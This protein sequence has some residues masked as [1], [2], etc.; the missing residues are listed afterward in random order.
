MNKWYRSAPAK[1]VLL[2]LQQVFVVLVVV[3][4]IW[5]AAY[6]GLS[7]DIVS[8]KKEDSY[9]D[10]EG[11]GKQSYWYA[12]DL[13]S[14]ISDKDDL[15]TD[16]TLDTNKL[17]DINDLCESG[18][19]SGQNKNGLAYTIQE[20][21][22]W[23]S[24]MEAGTVQASD[25]GTG[26]SSD[27]II[28][29]QKQDGGYDYYYY[30][31]LKK[32]V[33]AGELSFMTD[34]DT[35]MSSE[36]ILGNLQKNTLYQGDGA[37][38]MVDSNNQ[39]VYRTVW[40]YD[41][42]WLEEAYAP[43]GAGSIL[44]IV[45]DNPEWN[46]KLSE[47]FSNIQTAISMIQEK[48]SNYN[49]I[50]DVWEEGNTNLT[51]LY[52]D[53]SAKK[54][55]TNRTEFQDYDQ[56]EENLKKLKEEG[57]YTIVRP[58]LAQ[59][60]SN[61]NGVGADEWRHTVANMGPNSENFV[62]A[63]G[64]DTKY[65]VQDSYYSQNELFEKYA[66][67]IR[68]VILMGI[69][70]VA[71]ILAVIIWMTVTAG[72]SYKDE[73]LHLNGFDKIKTEIA[74]V[75]TVAA[76]YLLIYFG[77]N[78]Y[79]P[80]TGQI[81]QGS[82]DYYYAAAFDVNP[83]DVVAVSAI[84]VFTC[85]MFMIGYLSLVRRI[86]AGTIWK[87]SLLRS[88]LRLVKKV[89]D[90]IGEVWKIVIGL[91]AV[92]F[93]HFLVLESGGSVLLL[94]LLMVV[95]DILVAFYLIHQVIGRNKLG[96]GIQ[97]IAAGEVD[98]K[99]PLEGLKGGQRD[100][101]EKINSIGAGLDAAVEASMKNERL[102][103]DLI[104]NVSHD[105]KTPL[106]SIINYVDLLKREKFTDPK[107]ISYLDVLEAKSQR[108]KTLTED[109]VEASKVSSGNITLEYMNINL[110]EMIQQTSG[111]FEEKFKARSLKEVLSLPE[112]DVIIHVDG[113]R[114]WRVL[115]NIY[116]NA[117]KY[118]MEGTRIYADLSMDEKTVTFN[119]KNI[120][121]QP[122]NINADELTERFIR[123][124]VS[125]STEGSGLGLSI[126]RSLTEMQGGTFKLYLDGDL[127]KVTITFPR[128]KKV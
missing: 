124:D 64:I 80:F 96:A 49:S 3:S 107:I 19:I 52:A 2:V 28:V 108:L 38:T 33:E 63:I 62:Y 36:D 51:Y 85:L 45:N 61:M 69:L 31:E 78:I 114:M 4:L 48:M 5:L 44:D 94:D 89:A 37:G 21:Y 22:D 125:R 81:Y 113:R 97:K 105:I 25:V 82:S 77:I 47:A 39:V 30:S 104:T 93:L 87:N 10:S 127:F 122:L 1:G 71:G 74:A 42:Y 23:G 123:G 112:E 29:C 101:A 56:L 24:G 9:A 60:D 103:T 72:R 126:A 6:P 117:A 119:L 53:M 91:L 75:I 57:S 55:Y 58:T 16:G 67:S 90:H 7:E 43:D 84:G 111:E 120:S 41:G 121:Q 92:L 98:Y 106:T 88:L 86:K 66:P 12:Q 102:K 26:T 73:E 99:I 18:H 40:N 32:R 11:F 68:G 35:K 46:G 116:N 100:I 83:A 109:V 110:V 95:I 76:W 115:E 54:I 8:G 14:A 118:A 79:G 65:P 34:P 50:R 70:S 27:P 15:E 20:L 17:V 128:V 13:L 59:F